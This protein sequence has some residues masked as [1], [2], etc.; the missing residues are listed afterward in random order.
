ML[1]VLGR[2]HC[3]S[4]AG[5]KKT[6]WYSQGTVR[7]PVCSEGWGRREMGSCSSSQHQD[8]KASGSY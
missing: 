4:E 1:D 6:W 3:G 7:S 5:S 2:E 8:V